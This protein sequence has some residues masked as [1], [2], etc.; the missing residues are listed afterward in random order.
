MMKCTH[1]VLPGRSYYSSH[2]LVISPQERAVFSLGLLVENDA[3]SNAC[4]VENL[5]HSES[6][7]RLSGPLGRFLRP[8][9]IGKGCTAFCGISRAW[10]ELNN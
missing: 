6:R 3:S 9:S 10:P 7:I 4:G 5:G 2:M 1:W 8:A